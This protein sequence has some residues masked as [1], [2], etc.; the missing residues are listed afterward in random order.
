MLTFEQ[1]SKAIPTAVRFAT[2]GT[3]NNLEGNILARVFES[4]KQGI[5]A[6][7]IIIKRG[8]P[9]SKSW[10]AYRY[11]NQ[12]QIA[13]IDFQVFGDLLRSIQTV[14]DQEGGKIIF[15]TQDG[16]NKGRGLES[17]Y[18]QNIFAASTAE[19]DQAFEDF[20]RLFFIALDD[21]LATL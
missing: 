9:Y 14:E 1:I 5:D 12:R 21:E 16:V 19:A 2:K 15:A 11:R 8:K 17:L 10:A 7:G 13:Y 6:D 4:G 18:R 3:L 20:E